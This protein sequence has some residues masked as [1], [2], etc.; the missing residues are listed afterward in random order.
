VLDVPQRQRRR[1]N[2]PG[3]PST[4][5]DV[6]RVAGVSKAT[7]S[8]VLNGRSG[9]LRISDATHAAVL[10]A[11]SQLNYTPNHAARSLR[12]RRTGA[13][14]LIVSRVANPYYGEIATAALQAARAHGYQLDVAEASSAD[15]ERAA[16]ANLRSGRVDGVVVAT[17]RPAGDDDHQH[18][19]RAAARQELSRGGLPLVVLLDNSPDPAIPAIRIDDAE[20]AYLA[21]RH[22]LQL[23]HRRVGHVSYGYLPPAPHE[24]AASADRFNGYLRALAEADITP[25]RSWLLDRAPGMSGGRVAAGR[26]HA[27]AEPRPTALFAATDTAALGLIRGFHELGVRVPD[28][29]A[30]VGFDGVEAG[31]FSVPAVTTI[32]HPRGDLGRIG[33]ETLLAALSGQSDQGA[34]APRERVLPVKLV[35]R[36]SS[37]AAQAGAVL[38]SPGVPVHTHDEEESLL[39]PG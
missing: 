23:G 34:A 20:G 26:W 10:K 9:T 6:A 11:A 8:L 28:D 14:M 16:L 7:V 35:V 38:E 15:D 39:Q 25:D 29:V 22:L 1:A 36:E 5:L 13:I 24:N 30:I 31:Q 32:E 27:L 12:Q 4:I 37:G 21:T 3:R 18:A 33:V 19:L 17:A 2:L